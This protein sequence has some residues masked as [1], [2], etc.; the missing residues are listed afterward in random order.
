MEIKTS[1]VKNVQASGT[2]EDRFGLKY[3]FEIEMEDGNSGEYS[4]KSKDQDKFVI[5]KKVDY[6]WHDGKY[7]KIKLHYEKP[8]AKSGSQTVQSAQNDKVQ[9][10]IVRQSSIK[11]AIDYNSMLFDPDNRPTLESIVNDA[12]YFTRYVFKGLPKAEDLT[13]QERK[14]TDDLPY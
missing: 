1:I 4:S 6:E 5:G 2:H 14:E 11:A 8:V 10:Y 12:E 7:P 3:D 13:S 9:I